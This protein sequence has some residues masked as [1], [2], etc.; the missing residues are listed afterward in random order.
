MNETYQD[1]HTIYMSDRLSSTN[2][3]VPCIT[4][5]VCTS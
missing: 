1:L 4:Q 3:T 5:N 2:D